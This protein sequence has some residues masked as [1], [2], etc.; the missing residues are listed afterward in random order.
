MKHRNRIMGS[1]ALA[2]GLL[3]FTACSSDSNTSKAPATD[4]AAT[5]TDAVDEP[6][7]TNA[8][9]VAAELAADGSAD[10]KVVVGVDDFGTSGGTRVVSVPQGTEVTIELTDANADEEYHLHGYDVEVSGTKGETATL[11]FTADETGQFDLES[12]STEATLLV[13][14]V[15]QP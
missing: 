8:P 2:L 4:A 13:L 1:T 14:V 10:I 15:T 9:P 7:T 3:T 12:H 5:A 11:T 6:A